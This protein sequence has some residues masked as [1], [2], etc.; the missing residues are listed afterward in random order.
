M[1]NRHVLWEEPSYRRV[2][3]APRL[4][5]TRDPVRQAW[6]GALGPGPGRDA[7]GAD[8]RRPRGDGRRR[9]RTGRSDRGVGGRADVDALR[10]QLPA[11]H[12]SP[13]FS[14]GRRSRRTTTEDWPWGES[15]REEF[16]EAMAGLPRALEQ[17]A[18]VA[19]DLRSRVGVT[20]RRCCEWFAR[21]K[22]QSASPAAADDVHADGARDRRARC[23]CRRSGCPRSSSIP[24][25]DQVCHVEN[26]RYLARTIPGA[27]YV[28]LPGADHVMYAELADLALA[29]IREF[30]T[31]VARGAG[32]GARAR[33][34]PI[35]RPRRIHRTGGRA[36]R[37]ALA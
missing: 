32:A 6:H 22:V 9:L 25:G 15:T 34:R 16:E 24:S 27:R 33:D 19:E 28:E 5:C 26:A 4:L 3:R 30:L 31:G 29:E 10:G 17:C 2:R 8:G 11:A 18:L 13:C 7:R 14:A 23:R 36:R 35:H 37:Q 21:L 1:T 12:V 20:T